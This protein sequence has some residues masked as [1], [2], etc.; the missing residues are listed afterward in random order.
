MFFSMLKRDF[1]LFLR[2][3]LPALALTLAFALIC[4]GAAFAALKGAGELYTPVKAA[5]VDEEN[6][7]L[8]RLLVGAVKDTDYISGLMEISRRS[9]DEA[10]EGLEAGHYA[11]VIVLPEGFVDDI[12]LGERSRGRIILSSA[13]AS[14]SQV[15]ESAARF[16]ELLLAAGQYGVFSGEKLIREYDLGSEFH[17]AFLAQVNS[18]LLGEAM[19]A[20]EAYFNIEVTDYAGTSMPSASY[21]AVSW[22]TLLLLLCAVFFPRLYTADLTR[23]MLCRLKAAGV[24]DRAFVLGKLLFP[25]FFRAVLLLP[26]LMALRRFLDMELS[27]AALLLC[28]AAVTAASVIGAAFGMCTGNGT[29][30]SAIVAAAGLFL[31]GGIVPR[32]LLPDAVLGFGAV[33]PFGA[34]Q[35][36]MSP[37]FGGELAIAPAAAALVYTLAGLLWILRRIAALRVGGEEL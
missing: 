27:P 28:L 9:M 35:A 33:T 16:G 29:A 1:R 11:A 36:L 8:S 5:V 22:L 21:Y 30:C 37:A 26:V 31:C 17:N 7:I 15:V 19:D 32:Q 25:A 10:M 23:P 14:N 4:A 3:L 20:E 12:S 34:V 18:A 13:A 2:C 24:K 6:T